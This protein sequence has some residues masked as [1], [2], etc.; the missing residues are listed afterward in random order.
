[1]TKTIDDV[2]IFSQARLNSQRLPQKMIK[3]FAGRSL[4]DIMCKKLACLDYPSKFVSVY[5][6]E[7]EKIANSYDIYIYHRS[8]ASANEDNDVSL[9]WEICRHAPYKYY[10]MIN[11]CLPLLSTETINSF[12]Q[13][14][15]VSPHP[16]LF[17]VHQFA[18]YIWN[19]EGEM[20]LP[21]DIKMLNSKSLGTLYQASHSLYAGR[22]E[23]IRNGIQLGDF[24]KN[25]PELFLIKNKAECLDIDDEQDWK[26][27]EAV[28]IAGNK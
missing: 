26:I 4:W 28:Y 7:L 6:A 16:S 9:I 17:A 11:P 18:N 5:E 15:L 23:D 12:I 25:N 8:E 27:A 24:T 2:L 20:I 19:A 3:P 13:H 1:M 10:V 14:F 22:T 21:Q